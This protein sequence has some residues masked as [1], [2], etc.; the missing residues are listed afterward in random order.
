MDM[1][2]A[3]QALAIEYLMKNAG[4]LARSLPCAP[5][6]RRADL[7]CE[8]RGDGMRID[9][10]TDEQATY[11]KSWKRNVIVTELVHVSRQ[12]AL[13][14]RIGDRGHPDK[15][16]DQISD[17]M[18]DECLARTERPRRLRDPTTTGT[19]LVCGEITTTRGSTCPASSAAS[20]RT[21]ATVNADYGFDYQSCGVLTAIKNS[22]ARSRKA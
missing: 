6:A 1:S 22:R 17:G 7:T 21:S 15:L 10:M 12:D 5:R 2:F 18:L 11:A 16:C 13:H 4:T 14:Q 3:N 19:I 9:K 20:S 8:A